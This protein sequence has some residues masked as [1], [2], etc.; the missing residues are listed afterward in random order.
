MHSSVVHDL[1]NGKGFTTSDF[2]QQQDQPLADEEDVAEV[3]RAYAN[4]L[5]GKNERR[6]YNSSKASKLQ[7]MLTP[8][9]RRKFNDCKID[10]RMHIEAIAIQMQKDEN[11]PFVGGPYAVPDAVWPL[12][13][14]MQKWGNS[15]EDNP[16]Y[17]LHMVFRYQ[18]RLLHEALVRKEQVLQHPSLQYIVD[19]IYPNRSSSKF[20]PEF[21]RF[22][23]DCSERKVAVE[24]L[25][26]PRRGSAKEVTY[27][28]NF[29]LSPAVS[30]LRR[31]L[32]K[33]IARWSYQNVYP[34]YLIKGRGG[35]DAIVEAVA[36]SAK[37]RERQKKIASI[38]KLSKQ[39]IEKVA[40][41]VPQMTGVGAK[42]ARHTIR[43]SGERLQER[44]GFFLRPSAR[45]V[46][47]LVKENGFV[48]DVFDLT[49]SS[50]D[51]FRKFDSYCTAD[52]TLSFLDG[53]T[54]G[55]ECRKLLLLLEN[56]VF[57]FDV[58]LDTH[59]QAVEPDE[60]VR[61][62]IAKLVDYSLTP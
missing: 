57:L 30:A 14:V 49:C 35:N 27:S 22:M 16:K 1:V 28:N 8:A 52:L 51:H 20:P 34:R 39:V 46:F 37:A 5:A 15:P 59:L 55:N 10:V 36:S 41:A 19:V 17:Y 26:V 47:V 38:D 44:L 21:K 60:I 9:G 13:E 25:P 40:K 18:M 32:Q 43:T 3:I 58:A 53:D 31:K 50:F 24:S 23:H 54:D 12:I 61:K 11:V 45:E 7:A 42:Y 4:K 2:L 48:E 33:D 29:E 56:V 62:A 6:K